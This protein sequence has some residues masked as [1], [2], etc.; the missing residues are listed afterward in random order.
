MEVQYQGYCN[1]GKYYF[2]HHAAPL[3]FFP[4]HFLSSRQLHRPRRME[5]PLWVSP[6]RIPIPTHAGSSPPVVWTGV[7]R[8]LVNVFGFGVVVWRKNTRM[9][10]QRS[11]TRLHI[12]KCQPNLLKATWFHVELCPGA[13]SQRTTRGRPLR[14]CR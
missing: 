1:H 9:K 3:G 7:Y 5:A 11:A 12:V 6:L 10:I 13:L 2:P 14:G 4:R 8:C